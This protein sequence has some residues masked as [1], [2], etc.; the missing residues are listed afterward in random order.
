VPIDR[1]TDAG[2]LAAAA[3]VNGLT[4][5]HRHGRPFAS[6][7]DALPV[8]RAAVAVDPASVAELTP[9]HRAGFV[10]LAGRLRVVFAAL[11]GGDVAAAARTLNELLA[12]HPASPHLSLEDGRWRLHHHAA[13]TPVLPMW[14]AITAEGV[15]RLV[16]TGQHE[17]LGICTADACDRVYVDSSRN[18]SRRYCSTTCQNRVKAAAFRRR[19]TGAPV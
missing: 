8:V 19:R 10:A 6:P 2:L 14:T 16:G 17:R 11:D 13:G 7:A 5:G 15:A 3:L 12:A 18:G 9:A 4:P 1:Y